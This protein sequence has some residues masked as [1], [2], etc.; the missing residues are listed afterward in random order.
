MPSTLLGARQSRSNPPIRAGASDLPVTQTL[1]RFLDL[2]LVVAARALGRA[3]AV[4]E[5]AS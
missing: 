2:D 3:P 4:V 1:T 5:H